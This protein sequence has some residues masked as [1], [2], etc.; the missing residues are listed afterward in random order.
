MVTATDASLSEALNAGPNEVSLVPS[1]RDAAS[2][3]AKEISVD[4]S[5]RS[6][7]VT[8]SQAPGPTV[9]CS[10]SMI[11]IIDDLIF[12]VFICFRQDII[13][14]KLEMHRFL[15]CVSLSFSDEICR[16]IVALSCLPSIV[17]CFWNF[18]PALLITWLE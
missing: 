17:V 18:L 2:M 1:L 14:L 7:A 12:L 11:D 16:V 15:R 9:G 13:M 8:P 4:E 3:G 6:E 5:H 10:N